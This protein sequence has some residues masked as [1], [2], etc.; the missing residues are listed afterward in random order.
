MGRLYIRISLLYPFDQKTKGS[1]IKIFQKENWSS[2]LYTNIYQRK[3]PIKIG[4]CLYFNDL[5]QIIMED[6]DITWDDND[7]HPNEEL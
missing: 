1:Q 4:F 7:W 6:E 2:L 3:K 5:I